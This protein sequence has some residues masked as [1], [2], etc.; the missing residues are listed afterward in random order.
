MARNGLT[1][2]QGEQVPGNPPSAHKLPARPQEGGFASGAGVQVIHWPLASAGGRHLAGGPPWPQC[3]GTHRAPGVPV[4]QLKQNSAQQDSPVL[5]K[6][7]HPSPAARAESIDQ[8]SIQVLRFLCC[9]PLGQSP[10]LSE[11]RVQHLQNGHLPST[12]GYSGVTQGENARIW[13]STKCKG[14]GLRF[15]IYNMGT[16]SWGLRGFNGIVE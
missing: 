3:P 11:S 4:A 6:R 2:G 5:T 7:P 14:P 13:P 12:S 15:L 16:T 1:R 10:P 9:V 8:E